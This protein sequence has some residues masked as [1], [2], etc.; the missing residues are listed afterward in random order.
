VNIFQLLVTKL[1][2]TTVCT[3][4]L[5]SINVFWEVTLCGVRDSPKERECISFIFGVEAVKDGW[6]F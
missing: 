3:A 5:Q 4:A 6:N 1:L 2:D